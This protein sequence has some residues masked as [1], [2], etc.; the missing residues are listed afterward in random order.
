MRE[1][2]AGLAFDQAWRMAFCTGD[3]FSYGLEPSSLSFNEGSLFLILDGRVLAECQTVVVES[4]IVTG[5]LGA[6]T[7][8]AFLGGR[9]RGKLGL[10][11]S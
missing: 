11:E 1:W 6:R 4:E 2:R 10:P 3:Y 5:A 8:Q 7:T 9:C